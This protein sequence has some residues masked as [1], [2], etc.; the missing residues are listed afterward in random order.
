PLNEYKSFPFKLVHESEHARNSDLNMSS[1]RTLCHSLPPSELDGSYL[2]VA[3]PQTL[4]RNDRM[5]YGSSSSLSLAQ[6]CR[7]GGILGAPVQ[8]N[9][10]EDRNGFLLE[11]GVHGKCNNLV[12]PP[13]QKLPPQLVQLSGSAD[14]RPKETE[15][16]KRLPEERR[17]RL[18][19]QKL[20]L[21]IE[22]E[23][24]QNL[25]AKQEAKLLL[26]QQQ[27]HQSRLDHNRFKGH[28]PHSEEL[29]A[30]EVLMRSGSLAPVMNGACG[31]LSPPRLNCEGCL[32]KTPASGRACRAPGSNRGSSSGKKSV[33]FS[34]RGEGETLWEC[35]KKETGRPRR[36]MVAGAPKDAAT[37]PGLA[38]SRRELVTTGTSPIQPDTSR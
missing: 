4:Y 27:L 8:G 38:G 21:E 5:A 30:D 11:N 34:A 23:R 15:R 6:S 18:L 22:K 2:S 16:G 28:T 32:P 31:G 12:S 20:E 24:L 7:N 33:G 26:Q 1:Q 19:L 14:L 9:G 25:L 29:F 37:S 36:G 10:P 35:P 17:K 3:R 13:K